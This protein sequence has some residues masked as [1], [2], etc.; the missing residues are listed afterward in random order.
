MAS[1]PETGATAL[2]L[3]AILLWATLASLT[4]LA[5]PVPPFQTTAIAFIVGSSIIAGVALV[6]GQARRMVPTAASLALGI[7][8]FFLFHAF[9]FAA[10]KL[11]P[12][13]EAGLIASLWALFTV[14][15]SAFLPGVGLRPR[16]VVGAL[17]GLAAATLL[18]WD[19]LGSSEGGAYLVGYLLALGCALV[20]SSFSVISR[21]FAAVPSESLAV[22][23]FVT[24]ALAFIC[25][26]AF[27]GW[28]APPGAVSWLALA[29]LGIGPLGAAFV[30]WDVGMK[31][32]DVPL[33]GVLAYAA[34]LISTG[35]LV[36]LGFAEPTWKLGMACIFMVAGGL[37]ATRTAR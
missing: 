1:A 30:L 5:G 22:P 33:L 6:R 37:I 12:P 11:A 26:L 15:F 28:V 34:P 14:L 19:R 10:M 21:L 23:G 17:L 2:G 35:L 3:G 36:A 7:Y 32:G 27:E 8:G 18:V 25:N 9:Y 20:W 31:R 13:A 29:G 24:A 4:V 16:H